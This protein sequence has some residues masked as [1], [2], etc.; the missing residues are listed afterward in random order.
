[1]VPAA[2]PDLIPHP[3]SADSRVALPRTPGRC[4]HGLQGGGK[5]S[6]GR[7]FRG[8]QG[9]GKRSEGRRSRGVLTVKSR[10]D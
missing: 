10:A 8:L 7:R 9:K 3:I 4:F 5:R 1:M 2:L 6:E